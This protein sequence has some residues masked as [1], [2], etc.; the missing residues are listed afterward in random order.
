MRRI[1]WDDRAAF[2][3]PPYLWR[4]VSPDR[5]GLDSITEQLFGRAPEQHIEPSLERIRLLLDLLGNPERSA[6]VIQVAGTN[7]KSSTARMIDTLVRALGLRCGLYTSPHLHSVVERIQIDGRPLAERGPA[8]ELH[9]RIRKRLSVR[10]AHHAT[11]RR[12][13]AFEEHVRLVGARAHGRALPRRGQRRRS[14][15]AGGGGVR[16]APAGVPLQAVSQPAHRDCAVS[17]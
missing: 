11:Q 9:D 4:H 10:G 13:G 2:P 15:A 7:G 12:F 6:P 14:A 5:S 8:L 16:R 1:E 17:P 3:D